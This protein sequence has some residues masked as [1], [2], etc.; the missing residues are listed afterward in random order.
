[1]LYHEVRAI[2]TTNACFAL[3]LC[4][5]QSQS[6]LLLPNSGPDPHVISVPNTHCTREVACDAQSFSPPLRRAS[7]LLSQPPLYSQRVQ[8]QCSIR[9][10]L[11]FIHFPPIAPSCTF[12][13]TNSVHPVPRKVI[14]KYSC[15]RNR[16]FIHRSAHIKYSISFN[17]LNSSSPVQYN[18]QQAQNMT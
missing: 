5:G 16:H 9:H 14:I 17:L 10:Y 6:L 8:M 1:M 2:D 11:Q 18:L 13:P 3:K 4:L 12:S 15:Y 7:L